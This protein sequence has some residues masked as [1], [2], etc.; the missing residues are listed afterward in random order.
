MRIVLI[1]PPGAGKGTQAGIASARLDV[2]H[3]STGDI[4][5]ANLDQGTELGNAAR[6]AMAAGDLVPDELVVAMVRDRL[7]EP[8]AAGGFLLDGFP[9]SRPQAHALDGLLADLGI[10]LTAVLELRVGTEE[11]LR[12]LAV[13]GAQ[14]GRAD[15]TEQTVRHRQRVYARQT[16]PLVNHYAGQ[17]LLHTIDAVGEVDAVAERIRWALSV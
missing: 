3:I 8:D 9:R 14:S 15:D 2:P 7:A 13:R 1:G 17:G 16:A 10:P 12:R 5:R 6:A 11:V 4:F